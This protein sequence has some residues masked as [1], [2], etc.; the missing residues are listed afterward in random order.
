MI[1]TLVASR[2]VARSLGSSLYTWTSI[3]AVVLA[4]IS[5]GS[6][7]GGR[8][9]DRYHVRRVLAVLFGLSSAACVGIVVANHA[10][11]QWLGLWRLGWPSHVFLHVLLV[12]L[13]PSALLGAVSPVAA[14]MAVCSTSLRVSERANALPGAPHEVVGSV[15]HTIGSIYAWGAV[16][17]IVGTLLAGFVL[18]VAFGN[19]AILWLIGAA[20]L[21]MAILYW[22]SCWVMHLWA[23]V[24]M[25]LATMGMA[26]APW[27]REAPTAA[28]LREKGDPNLVYAAETPYGHVAVR[29]VSQ[30]PDKRI[31]VQDGSTRSEMI[32]TDAAHP[33]YF[34]LTIWAGLTQGLSGKQNPSMLVIGAGG[35]AFPRCLKALWPAGRVEAVEIDPGVTK[36]ARAA[37][38]LEEKA[39]IATVNGE[40]RGHLDRVLKAGR[41][42][43]AA[44]RYDFIY[45]DLVHDHAVPRQWMTKEFHGRIAALLA[46]DGAYMIH[47][48]DTCRSGRL[49]GAAVNTLRETFSHVYVIAGQAGFSYPREASVVVAA[50]RRLDPRAILEEY[51]ARPRFSVL[52]DAQIDDLRNRCGGIILTDD[53][54]PVE[55]L[56]APVV[57]HSAVEML[58][59]KYLDR[60]K[61]LQ[62]DHQYEQSIRWY[63]Q[64]LE[65]DPLLAVEAYEQIGL[66]HVA[67]NEPEEAVEAFRQALAAHARVG[68]RQAA[69]GS[70]HLHLGTVLGRLDKPEEAR[71]QLA[72]AVEEFRIE[73]QECPGAVTVWERLGDTAAALG[74]FPGASEAF[75]KAMTLEPRNPTHY[76]KLARALELQHCYREAVAVVEQHV[77]L[78]EE[79]GRRD[80]VT[81]LNQYIGLLR[82]KNVKQPK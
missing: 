19:L 56:L 15:G 72:K 51:R 61:E 24:F 82:Y 44:R 28:L 81:Q 7:L 49:L 1:L 52:D 13:L 80:Q 35:Y 43:K 46:D 79:Q 70:V 55:T 50:Q 47:L 22:V 37:F 54:A 68:G 60:A 14:K 65:T 76:Q 69:V 58:A 17:G 66:I 73:L 63:R 3:V 26:D 59:R 16:G 32:V 2:L 33:T 25:A 30:R 45:Q 41:A 48:P 9:A 78:M 11:D 38:G 42:G 53:Y 12:F 39:A 64:A 21:A 67:K 77:K 6:Y 57:K 23:M 75:D 71:E 4:G 10:A 40:A 74:D 29:Q 36:A 20:L 8:L 18:I 31:F 34:H 27:A 5:L 62:S